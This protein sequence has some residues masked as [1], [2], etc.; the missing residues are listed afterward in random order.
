MLKNIYNFFVT[1]HL[2][3]LQIY[4]INFA[5]FSKNYSQRFLYTD[6]YFDEYCICHPDEYKPKV[7][8]LPEI[9]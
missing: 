8:F 9:S 4:Y 7:T 3:I 1:R 2:L 6:E 5:E